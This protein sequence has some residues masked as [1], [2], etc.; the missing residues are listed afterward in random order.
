MIRRLGRSAFLLFATITVLLAL[1]AAQS[2]TP[3]VGSNPPPEAGENPVPPQ[4][5]KN[6]P[7]T[8]VTGEVS[9]S[10]CLRHH[11]MLAHATDAECVR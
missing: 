8:S 4:N 3:S 6:L 1:A 10:Y 7:L 5:A 9:D 11:Y 2:G